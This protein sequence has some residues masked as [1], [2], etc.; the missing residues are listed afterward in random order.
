MTPRSRDIRVTCLHLLDSNHRIKALEKV[1]RFADE[2]WTGLWIIT[3][4]VIV[5]MTMITIG[6]HIILAIRIVPGIVLY[7]HELI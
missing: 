3:I 2:I 6:V 4:I 5:M 7:I 1:L